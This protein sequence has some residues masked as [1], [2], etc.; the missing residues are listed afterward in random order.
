MYGI[1]GKAYMSLDHVVD[2]G[3]INDLQ[4]E[5]LR[6]LSVIETSFSEGREYSRGDAAPS[7]YDGRFKD[8][9][10]AEEE[11]SEEDLVWMSAL[12]EIQRR[13]YLMYKYGA[14]FP[15]GVS[16]NLLSNYKWT[17]KYTSDGRHLVREAVTHFPKLIDFCYNSG[18]FT[19]IGRI[20]V[21]G[22]LPCQHGTVHRDTTP[23]KWNGQSEF[24]YL[25]PFLNKKFFI[26]DEKNKIKHYVKAT[27]STFN[28]F[29]YHGTDAQP[30]FSYSVRIDGTFTPE[31]KE[32]F[33][34]GRNED[35]SISEDALCME[36][37][38]IHT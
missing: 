37:A 29:D 15:W 4:D 33:Q 38:E 27:T 24:L 21:L 18:F 34:H 14:Y 31:W 16:F 13:R 6:G 22:N 10:F 36:F 11:I 7:V 9:T 28:D 35:L 26:W 23:E 17:T 12:S 8:M 1:G 25:N 5:I 20:G 30:I 19:E 3:Q 2:P 32:L